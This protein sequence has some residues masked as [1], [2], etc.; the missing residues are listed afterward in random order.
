[1]PMQAQVNLVPNP[2]FDEFDNCPVTGG[3]LMGY[4]KDWYTAKP[5]PDYYNQCATGDVGAPN[6]FYGFQFPKSGVAYMGAGTYSAN[7]HISVPL[8]MFQVRLKE[9]LMAGKKYCVSFFVSPAEG[10]GYYFDCFDAYFSKT[11]SIYPGNIM[12][13]TQVPQITNVP[14]NI[15]S[16]ISNWSEITGSFIAE[17]DEEYL[18]LG[19]FKALSGIDTIKNDSPNPLI[20]SNTYY[21]YEDVSVI[22]C[23]KLHLDLVIV[24]NI[25]TPNG[26]GINDTLS[27]NFPFGFNI[28]TSIFIYNRWGTEVYKTNNATIEFW[29][30]KVLGRLVSTGVYYYIISSDNNTKTGFVHVSY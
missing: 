29:D 13:G 24:P 14:G 5:T 25:F 22:Y 17:G 27:I 4:V 11:A 3:N 20:T 30:G 18:T 19:C 1:M 26:D 6:N 12:D 21:Y 15:I 8:E 2:G 16:D 23:D 7:N 28:K 9:K 10:T